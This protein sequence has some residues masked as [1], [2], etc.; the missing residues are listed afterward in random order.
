MKKVM[1]LSAA[2]LMLSMAMPQFAEANN[3]QNNNSMTQVLEV[4]YQEITVA[5]LPEAVSATLT[6]DYA[7]YTTDKVF[8]GSDGTYK[9]AVSKAEVKEVLFFDA[10]GVFVKAE[11]PASLESVEPAE[12]LEPVKSE[13]SEEPVK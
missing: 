11:Q 12:S 10:T 1:I 4:Q 5:D 9:V 8:L 2:A 3:V 13:E 6:K 7:G